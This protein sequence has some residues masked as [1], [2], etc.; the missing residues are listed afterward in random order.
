MPKRVAQYR[1]SI[2]GKL[3][4]KTLGNNIKMR[5]KYCE[6]KTIFYIGNY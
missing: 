4:R 1:V 3:S 5:R 6:K 2:V